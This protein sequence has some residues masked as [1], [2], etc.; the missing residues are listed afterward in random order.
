MNQRENEFFFD[1]VTQNQDKHKPL[2]KRLGKM[3]MPVLLYLTFSPEGCEMWPLKS[4]RLQR[5]STNITSFA[6][7]CHTLGRGR[8]ET[9]EGLSTWSKGTDGSGQM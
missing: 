6:S 5:S 9:E 1:K 8:V 4:A 7:P 2:T 3:M